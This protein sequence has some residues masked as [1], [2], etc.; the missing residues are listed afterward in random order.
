[1]TLPSEPAALTQLANTN[2]DAARVARS[3]LTRIDWPGKPA[4]VASVAPLTREE[5]RRFDA[6]AELYKNL[7]IAC[8]Q[9]DGRGR[10]KM[11]PSLVGSRFVVA[12]DAGNVARIVIGGMEGAIGLM[13]P[14]AS[15]LSDTQIAAVLTYVRREWGHTASAV[16]PDD[17]REIRGLT[18]TRTRP[19]T[20]AE[21]PQG[22]G[23][24]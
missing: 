7:C 15:S 22:R 13:P 1:V 10:E 2:A 16:S 12:Q 23:G 9:A 5:Q 21:L 6:G 24:R 14:M 4:P 8:H 18:R 3:I 17:V 19:W 11:A 20:A